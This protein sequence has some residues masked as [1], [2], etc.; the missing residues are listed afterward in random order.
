MVV[1]QE[2][3][4]TVAVSRGP[5]QGDFWNFFCLKGEANDW[6]VGENYD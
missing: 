1:V 2:P 3:T 6:G 5:G 4:K